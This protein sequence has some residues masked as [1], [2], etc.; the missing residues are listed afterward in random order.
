[1]S[2]GTNRLKTAPIPVGHALTRGELVAGLRTV[3]QRARLDLTL[4]REREAALYEMAVAC[5]VGD[6]VEQFCLSYG[7]LVEIL[8]ERLAQEVAAREAVN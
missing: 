6:V 1:M 7:E 4:E 8:G 5:V 3:Y 2:K